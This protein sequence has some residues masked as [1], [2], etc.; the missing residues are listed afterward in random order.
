MTKE[1]LKSGRMKLGLSQEKMG[2]I[3]GVRQ[4]TYGSWELGKQR[5]PKWLIDFTSKNPRHRKP[6]DTGNYIYLHYSKNG[7]IDCWADSARE[8][9]EKTGRTLGTVYTQISKRK[10]WWARIPV[11]D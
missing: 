9:A 7:E 11:D 8:L 3:Y 1:Q 10:P 5:I 4:S 6:R 2:Q